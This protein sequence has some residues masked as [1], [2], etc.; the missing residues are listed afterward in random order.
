MSK[1]SQNQI[2]LQSNQI[3]LLNFREALAKP[4]I[5]RQLYWSWTQYSWYSLDG[6]Y[7]SSPNLSHC[8]VLVGH[9]I[10]KQNYSELLFWAN[11]WK[12]NHKK[13]WYFTPIWLH[14]QIFFTLHPKIASA[15]HQVFS[16]HSHCLITW[17]LLKH[18]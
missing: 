8:L 17:C 3:K 1:H 12:M 14:C 6:K 13:R 16:L 10:P 4:H 9:F 18:A 15:K 5:F 2:I 11:V 7:V